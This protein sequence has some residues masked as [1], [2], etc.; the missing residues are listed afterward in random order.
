MDFAASAVHRLGSRAH[1][2]LA[3]LV[4]RPLF[5]LLFIVLGLALPIVRTLRVSLPRSLPVLSSVTDFQLTDQ[6]GQPFGTQQLR[7]RVWVANA[8]FTRC[9]TVCPASTQYMAQVQHRGRGLG[10]YFH[11]VSFT[12]DPEHDTP[13]KLL[14][15]AKQ[16]KVS[17]RMWSF[18]TGSRGELTRILNDGLKIYMGKDQT[19]DDD[20]MSIGHG[21]HFVL[22][23]GRMRIR[24]YYDLTAEGALDA[25]LRDAGLLASRGD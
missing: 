18:V 16:H 12:V 15:Y 9:P 21:S 19:A 20:L 2:R 24:G 8:I 1:E 5:W 11:L 17:P 6:N 25:L 22:V 3:A 4:S 13:Q 10:E 14:D 23:D 7:G